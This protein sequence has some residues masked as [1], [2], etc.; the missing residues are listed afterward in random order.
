MANTPAFL[1]FLA[2]MTITREMWHDGIGYDTEALRGATPE[3]LAALVPRLAACADWRDVEAL[4]EIAKIGNN[5]SA[6]PARAA[7]RA[8]AEGQ[9]DIAMRAQ[10][11]LRELGEPCKDQE[12][13][14]IE[15]LNRMTEDAAFDRALD[16]SEDYPDSA[17]IKWA[18]LRGA[19]E[20]P[21]RGA[22]CAAMLCFHCGLASEAFDWDHRPFFLRF[23]PDDTAD[24]MKAFEELCAKT[25]LRLD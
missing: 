13:S 1:R 15:A 20:H 22:H 6:Q 19:R 5:A 11:A 7:L 12:Q 21:A 18:L 24:R 10:D 4:R 8:R 2:S 3:E 17:A 9:D 23:N 25:G 16:Q 14:I